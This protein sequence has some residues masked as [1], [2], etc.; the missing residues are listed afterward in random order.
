M[1]LKERIYAGERID[2]AEATGLFSWDILDL[3]MAADFRTNLVS[4]GNKVS[5]IVDRIV[6][7][8][9]V[10]EASCAFCAFHACAG[11]IEPYEL[12]IDEILSKVEELVR[13]GGTQVMLQGGLHPRYTID[14]YID[15]IKAIKGRFPAI[16]LH[17]FSPAELVH[18]ARKSG[19]TLDETLERLKAAGLNSV[20]GA[21]DLLVDRIRRYAS[22]K[23]LTRDEWCEVMEAFS[24]HGLKSSAT[25][26][27][28]MGE[29]L[30]ERV[31][32]LD[33]I[34]D[35]QDR[36]GIL[37]AFIP[38]SFSPARTDM[39]GMAASTGI[40]YL[41]V[42]AV[43]RIFLDNVVYIQAGWLTEGMKMAQ[44][45]LKMGANDMG[46]VLMEET[47][48]K[49]T[50]IENR[51]NMTELIDIIKDAGKIPFQRDSEYREIRTFP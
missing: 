6:N 50:G 5:F 10:C 31:A 21:S 51:T 1:R 18:I 25:M 45:A 7:F 29:T 26:T 19:I 20:P 41:K 28:G 37:R 33:I 12:T 49:A 36:A 4:P 38:W 44:V 11:R 16:Y 39:E 42:V 47:V 34:R 9:N 27:Y 43:S 40:D 46:G 22:P 2:S 35:I 17:S 24:R 14:T 3:G 48:V 13:I 15:M 8:T 30:E 32:H 23:K